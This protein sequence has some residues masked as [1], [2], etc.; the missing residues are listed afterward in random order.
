VRVQASIT[1]TAHDVPEGVLTA[2]V[3]SEMDGSI[4]HG[5]ARRAEKVSELIARQI[6]DDIVR[7]QLQPG[8]T[9]EPE[10]AMLSRYEVSRASLREALRILEVHGLISIKP[11]PG[12]GPV[13]SAV[14]SVDFGTT[15]TL[16][17]K[18]A[19]ATFREL[20]EA[21]LVIEPAMAGLAARR[22]DSAQL[23]ALQARLDEDDALDLSDDDVYRTSTREFHTL[24]SNASE[25]RVMSLFA[26]GLKAVYLD[27][28]RQIVFPE[29]DR[30]RV[31]RAHSA[32]TRAILKG[33][34]ARAERLM[35]THMEEY[36]EFVERRFPGLLD[37]LI[38]WR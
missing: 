1:L 31:V 24:V 11:G 2:Q 32:I 20:V 21:R 15:S 16:Y 36:V 18:A 9:L 23:Q 30:Q 10:A 33:D 5:A 37:E 35:R 22:G 19:G 38:D 12:G 13:V 26:G 25:N 29:Q 28:L 3:G 17:F 27:R 14:D 8:D 6:V 4:V 34:A 7:R